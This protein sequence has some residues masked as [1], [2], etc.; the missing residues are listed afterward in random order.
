MIYTLECKYDFL[1]EIRFPFWL[2][3]CKVIILRFC[4][5]DEECRTYAIL[6]M[7]NTDADVSRK[8]NSTCI[9]DG[10]LIVQ[11]SDGMSW[12]AF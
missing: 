11:I 5:T 7:D 4:L 12:Y 3:V 8:Y 6:A 9:G 10:G 1:S 2:S